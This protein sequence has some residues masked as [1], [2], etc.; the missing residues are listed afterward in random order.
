MYGKTQ[1]E[2]GLLYRR[3]RYLQTSATRPIRLTNDRNNFGNLCERSQRWNRDLGS[4]EEHRAH[5][6]AYSPAWFRAEAIVP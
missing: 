3:R 4:A 6:R 5:C 1:L 2:R